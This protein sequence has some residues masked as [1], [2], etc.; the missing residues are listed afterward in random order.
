MIMNFH[1]ERVFRQSFP[2]ML[3]FALDNELFFNKHLKL[4]KGDNSNVPLSD[5]VP[6]LF[7]YLESNNIMDSPRHSKSESDWRVVK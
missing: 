5:R 3:N 2:N 7:N 4:Y 6:E 1:K